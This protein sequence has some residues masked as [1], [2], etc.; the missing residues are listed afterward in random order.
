MARRVAGSTTLRWVRC[1]KGNDLTAG[2]PMAPRCRHSV[3]ANAMQPS[4][5]G[6]GGSVPVDADQ[7]PQP[8]AGWRSGVCPRLT[9]SAPS[10]SAPCWPAPPRRRDL[11][12]RRRRA[13]AFAVARDLDIEHDRVPHGSRDGRGLDRWLADHAFD[14]RLVSVELRDV[15]R[16]DADRVLAAGAAPVEIRDR[17]AAGEE[18]QGDDQPGDSD[19][20]HDQARRSRPPSRFDR[21]SFSSRA[22]TTKDGSSPN[23]IAASLTSRSAG[24]DRGAPRT[25]GMPSLTALR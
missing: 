19:D 20:R 10:H 18:Q 17:G 25:T 7:Q 8:A 21:F 23:T 12:L 14:D 4:P 2:C 6:A 11:A 3:A 13:P 1:G 24:A 22:P 9:P 15:R 16:T 5:R